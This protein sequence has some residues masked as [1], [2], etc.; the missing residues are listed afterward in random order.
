MSAQRYAG[1]EW[2]RRNN[3]AKMSPLGEQVADL[4]GDLVC[5]IYHIDG[6]EKF[7][8]AN[9]HCI[10]VPWKHNDLA[11]YDSNQLTRLVFF[12]HDRCLRVSVTPR[13]H[14]SLNLRFW[15]RERDAVS[16]FQR[17]PTVEQSLAEHRKYWPAESETL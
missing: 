1:A 14:Q 4:L 8:W 7:D 11:T 13:S 6:V 2:L 16:N 9:P 5:G 12:A 15:R 10:E 17:H 3:V